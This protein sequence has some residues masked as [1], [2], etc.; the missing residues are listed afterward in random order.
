M[1]IAQ[2]NGSGVNYDHYVMSARVCHSK[3][4]PKI[5]FLSGCVL[6]P[7]MPCWLPDSRPSP[8]FAALPAPECPGPSSTPAWPSVSRAVQCSE[9]SESAEHRKR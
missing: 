8:L 2:L 6:V 9:H 4:L 3:Q 1:W 5:Q 7:L